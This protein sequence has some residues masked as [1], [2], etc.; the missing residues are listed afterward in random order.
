MADPHS[1]IGI[2]AGRRFRQPGIPMVAEATAHPA[3]FPD[4]MVAA[5]GI[6]PA[7]PVHL[8]D[9]FERE[10]RYRTVPA[11]EGAIKDAVRAAVL[12]NAG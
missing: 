1:A 12:S 5:T 2:A 3:K 10:E 6:H 8:A 9:L 7:L 4:A 11:T